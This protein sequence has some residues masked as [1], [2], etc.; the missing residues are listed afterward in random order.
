MLIPVL[1]ANQKP[2]EQFL[3]QTE[4]SRTFFSAKQVGGKGRKF[5]ICCRNCSQG[6][7]S[8]FDFPLNS[9]FIQLL[10]FRFTQSSAYEPSARSLFFKVSIFLKSKSM[11][12]FFGCTKYALFPKEHQKYVRSCLTSALSKSI[13]FCK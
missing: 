9:T 6:S 8:H 2:C 5:L 1:E 3:H 10:V 13:F 7:C 4:I 12:V 11:L